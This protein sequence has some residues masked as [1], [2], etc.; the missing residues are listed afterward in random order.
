MKWPSL[1]CK[2]FLIKVGIRYGQ[3]DSLYSL[4]WESLRKHVVPIA[5]SSIQDTLMVRKCHQLLWKSKP[6]HRHSFF[7]KAPKDKLLILEISDG[8][9]PLCKF[10]G[11]PVPDQPFPHKNKGGKIFD[12]L[13]NH[14]LM[15]RY[16]REILATLS[17]YLTIGAYCC[18]KIVKRWQYAQEAVINTVQFLKGLLK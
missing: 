9:D 8:W 11:V 2:F 16:S 15:I 7:Q 6:R 18:Y 1:Y 3:C 17:V 12:A 13:Q 14:P 5:N 10:L 4:P